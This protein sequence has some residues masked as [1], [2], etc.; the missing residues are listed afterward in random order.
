MKKVGWNLQS[1]IELLI[2]LSLSLVI[3]MPIVTLAFI[4]ISS[5]SSTLSTT[6]AQAAAQK[7]A[8]IASQVGAQGFPA[9]QLVTLQVP[10]NV[11]LIYLGNL[12][13]TIGNEIIFVVSVNGKNSY[14]TAYTPV[15][16]SGYLPGIQ[17]P[18]TYLI[19]VSAQAN[20][21]SNPA[22]PCVFIN[23]FKQVTTTTVSTCDPLFC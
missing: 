6:E 10:Q 15:N 22:L 1:S 4:Q 17:S 14:V 8:S 23:R 5:S 3:L 9:R 7:L 13:N 2:T 16:V 18:A 11:R 20:C 21:P 12:A 19:N